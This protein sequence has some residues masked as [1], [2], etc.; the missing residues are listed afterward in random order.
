[1]KPPD[2]FV[3]TPTF[4]AR[5]VLVLAMGLDGAQGRERQTVMTVS[6]LT[7]WVHR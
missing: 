2:V 4:D 6:A 7:S 1:M 5:R 3:T